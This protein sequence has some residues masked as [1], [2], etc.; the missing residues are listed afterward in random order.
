MA[1]KVKLYRVVKIKPGSDPIVEIQGDPFLA[2]GTVV[3]AADYA[4]CPEFQTLVEKICVDDGAGGCIEGAILTLTVETDCTT[5]PATVTTTPG[6]V[7]L[8]DG[9]V[10]DLTANP[11]IPCPQYEITSED[12]CEIA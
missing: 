6:S 1:N 2:D 11:Q 5:T 12:G 8:P 9:T 7:L 10:T 4:I 3:N